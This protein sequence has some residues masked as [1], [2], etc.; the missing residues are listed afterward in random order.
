MYMQ[1]TGGGSK[2]ND[3][4]AQYLFEILPNSSIVGITA[5]SPEFSKTYVHGR[6]AIP[7]SMRAKISARAQQSG[8]TDVHL[9]SKSD[10]NGV[11][12]HQNSFEIRR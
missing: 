3:P 10:L 6:S 12:N 4:K 7:L 5:D 11:L 1:L 8:S 2:G 9:L